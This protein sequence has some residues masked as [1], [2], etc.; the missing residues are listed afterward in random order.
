MKALSLWQPWASL[1]AA[2][3]KTFETRSWAPPAALWPEVIGQRIAI[4][5][6]SRRIP[7]RQGTEAAWLF[8][9]SPQVEA[10]ATELFGVDWRI[11]LPRG[12]VLCTARLAGCYQVRALSGDGETWAVGRVVPN[13]AGIGE[14]QPVDPWGDFTVGRWIWWLQDV[15]AVNPPAP[16]KGHQKLWSWNEPVS[17]GIA[18]TSASPPA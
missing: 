3:V 13:S 14:F 5:A 12:P 11:T 7:L 9:I 18:I 8:S 1:I 6:S 15:R 16:A 17:T 4:H 10:K 2:G